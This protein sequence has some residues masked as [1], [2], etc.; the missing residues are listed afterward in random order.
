[1][2]IQHINAMIF[3]QDASLADYLAPE[4]LQVPLAVWRVRVDSLVIHSRLTSC[5]HL[6]PPE[7]GIIAD[8][9]LSL[10]WESRSSREDSSS[11]NQCMP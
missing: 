1:M 7:G 8:E 9:I 3:T 6:P 11:S 4:S 10:Y 2:Q 5:A